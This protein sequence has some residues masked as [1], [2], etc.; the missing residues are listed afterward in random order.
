MHQQKVTRRSGAGSL[1][2]RPPDNASSFS[3]NAEK[4]LQE[5]LRDAGDMFNSLTVY[6]LLLLIFFL[7]QKHTNQTAGSLS[8]YLRIPSTI[9]SP[10]SLGVSILVMVAYIQAAGRPKLSQDIHDD[11][12]LLGFCT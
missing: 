6:Q 4:Y 12:E 8:A 5:Q 3:E 1:L 2:T 10:L 9:S 11:P 7:Y